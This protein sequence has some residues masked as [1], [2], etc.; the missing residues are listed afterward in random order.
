LS[1]FPETSVLAEEAVVSAEEDAAVESDVDDAPVDATAS[2]EDAD[3]SFAEDE[4]P[5]RFR[6]IFVSVPDDFLSAV[7]CD[8]STRVDCRQPSSGSF[9]EPS[10]HLSSDGIEGITARPAASAGTK[11]ENITKR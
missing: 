3:E 10:G 11:N 8:M 6:Y 1:S 9:F 4:A 7:A 5:L 2:D